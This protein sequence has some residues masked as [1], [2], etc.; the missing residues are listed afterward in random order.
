MKY[1]RL[2]D[3]NNRNL[4]YTVLEVQGASRFSGLA[5]WFIEGIFSLCPHTGEAA[6]DLSGVSFIRAVTY[7]KGEGNGTPL[8]YSC[9]ENPM[10][11]RAW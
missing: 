8:Q 2:G 1:Y 6:R 10:D 9:L 7:I 11:R 3:L 4:F 5:F